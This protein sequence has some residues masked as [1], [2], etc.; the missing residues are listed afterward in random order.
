M[1][2]KY[3]NLISILIVIILLVG[4]FLNT[5][6]ANK[7][8]DRFHRTIKIAG[9]KH[10]P[11]YEYLTKENIYKGFNIDI[12]RAIAIE[13]G[14]DIEIIPMV[15]EEAIKALKE[16]KVDAIQGMAKS[17]ERKN[18]YSFTDELLVSDQRI[19]VR[20]DNAFI[21]DINSL[22]DIKLA[23]QK[24]DINYELLQTLKNA[25]I[26]TET[27]QKLGI[28]ALINN[29]VDTFIGNRLTGLYHL[30]KKRQLDKVKI[31]GDPIN[32][33][34][35]AIATLKD[36]NEILD[37]LNRGLKNIKANGT[38]DKIYKKW[39][40]ET[41]T[42]NSQWKTIAIVSSIILLMAFLLIGAN[43]Y[44]NKKLSSE[45]EKRTE[46]IIAQKED[47]DRSNRLRG[48]ILEG[49]GS[50]IIALDQDRQVLVFNRAAENLL[51]NEIE[52][53]EF[54]E[55]L[56]ISK[57]VEKKEFD[58]IYDNNT[59]QSN[60]E[61][62]INNG[63]I[64]YIDCR[65]LP[66]SG[67]NG[68][69]GV[70]VL[71]HNYT[72]EKKLQNIINYNDKMQ[73]IGKLAAGIAH[74]IKNPLA[75]IKGFISLMLAKIDKDNLSQGSVDIVNKEMDRLEGL[76]MTLLDYS[77]PKTENIEEIDLVNLIEEILILFSVEIKKKDIKIIKKIEKIYILGDVNQIKQIIINL[78]LNSIDAVEEQGIIEINIFAKDN[79]CI[80]DIIDNGYGIPSNVIDKVFDPFYTSKKEGT[81]I[82]LAI[83]RRLVKENNGEMFVDSIENEGTTMTI[84][85]PISKQ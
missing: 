15:W 13:E 39:F 10:Y 85:F 68:V 60:I 54:W 57:I 16:G 49:I 4:L 51:D 40:G 31:V 33:T 52:L 72:R 29:E 78:L 19:F 26:V 3:R 25:N 30:Q 74:E 42:D 59:W 83:S 32:T 45:V 55:N 43:M 8:K 73:A 17:K 22:S 28:E 58:K 50:G 20:K 9:D 48:K 63:D 6:L 82:G 11:P 61:W 14:L 70:I 35:Y 62:K 81:G 76:I 5:S 34:E 24:D 44:W 71:L 67:P 23:V 1:R 79:D 41:F 18:I 7:R 80:I 69:E 46:Q 66:I 37:I 77:K 2:F 12:I 38:Y 65:V 47:I 53:G 21:S 56:S 64:Q 75:S 27:N 84:M 36:N